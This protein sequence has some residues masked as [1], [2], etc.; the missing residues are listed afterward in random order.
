MGRCFEHLVA[1]DELLLDLLEEDH[2]AELD[3]LRDLAPHQ[4]LGMGLEDAEQFLGVGHLLAGEDAAGGLVDDFQGQAVVALELRQQSRQDQAHLQI[5]GPSLHTL[6][7]SGSHLPRPLEHARNMRQQRSIW[8]FQL[9]PILF[10]VGRAPRDPQHQALDAAVLETPRSDGRGVV[11]PDPRNQARGHTVTIPQQAGVGR[12]VDV[13]LARRGIDPQ[14]G[15]ADETA[16]DGVAT[17]QLIHLL[18]GLGRDRLVCSA[19][20]G[21]VHHVAVVEAHEA[22]E[23]MAVVDPHHG[24]AVGQP[25]DL[26]DQNGAQQLVAGEVGPTLPSRSAQDSRHVAMKDERG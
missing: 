24:L 14:A 25:L 11:V 20:Q 10:L 16:I 9:A 23:E 6:A 19:Q 22:A 21:V 4:Q 13:G 8:P 5:V 15:A 26:H 2:V 7:H 12:V 3:R 18:P 1:G 17:E